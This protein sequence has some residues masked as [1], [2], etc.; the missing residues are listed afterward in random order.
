VN[1]VSQQCKDRQCQV[2]WE[3]T[4]FTV[5]PSICGCLEWNLLD[6][7][8]VAPRILRGFQIFGPLL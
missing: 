7:T 5:A 8:C 4:F 6:V 3:A 2:T 1:V